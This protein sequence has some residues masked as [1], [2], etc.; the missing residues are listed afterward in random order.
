MSPRRTAP[1]VVAVLIIAVLLIGRGGGSSHTV[2]ATFL[3]AT[4]LVDG[5][6]V[7]AAGVPVGKVTDIRLRDGVVDVTLKITDEKIWPLRQGTRAAIRFGGTVSYANRYVALTPGPERAP[8]LADGAR[9]PTTDTT[10][11]VEFDQL[12]NTFNATT[13]AGLGKL[14]DTGSTT[15]GSRGEELRAGLDGAAP[16]YREVADVLSDLGDDPAALRSLVRSTA[17]V[18]AQV[19]GRQ[20]ELERFVD[21]GGATFATVAQHAR[22]TRAT[23]SRLPG[24]LTAARTALTRVQPSLSRLRRLARS[25]QPGTAELRDA[26][27]PLSEA[28]S[29]LRGAAPDLDST[30]A[31]L[32]RGAPSITRLLTTARPVLRKAKPALSHLNP[33]LSCL[34]AYAPEVASFFPIWAAV[35]AH[36]DANGHYAP[37]GDQAL[38]FPGASPMNAAQVKRAFPTLDYTFVRPPGYAAGEAWFLPQCG[39]DPSGLDPNHDPWVKP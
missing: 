25:L 20:A 27:G 14:I 12:F 28:V 5:V 26:A 34:R 36:Y 11:P 18:A 22:S 2:H 33:M 23:L 6:R 1:V 9:L 37:V 29:T 35:T 24:T 13:R 3:A 16:T 19:R 32:H 4:N 30:L 7:T 38:P 10:T 39:A 21:A 31:T 8:V 17:D 15:F